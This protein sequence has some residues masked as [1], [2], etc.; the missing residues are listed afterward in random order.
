MLESLQVT[1]ED[2]ST[3]DQSG[4]R[5]GSGSNPMAKVPPEKPLTREQIQRKVNFYRFLLPVLSRKMM[6]AGKKRIGKELCVETE[7]GKVGVLAYN[8]E[9]LETLPLFVNI[10]GSGFTIG[11]AEMDDRFMP[12]IALKA[13]VKILSID[14][15]L[16][17]EAMFPVALNE[18]Y[19]VAKY[20]KQ[21]ATELG[22]DPENMGVRGHSAGGNFSAA[23][24]LLDVERR[25]LGL[26]CLILD[27]P[28]VGI[29]PTHI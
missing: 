9:N 8:L 17:P 4:P 16:A 2:L 10:H 5:S 13:N 7:V 14:Y 15:S 26:K 11:H 24:C 6:G 21:H 29:I 22:I 28:P 19:A 23:I 3:S 12:N 20:A 25:E 1:E 27:Y 18:C